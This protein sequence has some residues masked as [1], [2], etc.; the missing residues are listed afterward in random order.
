MTD[1]SAHPVHAI[2]PVGDPYVLGRWHRDRVSARG[3]LLEARVALKALVVRGRPERF[4]ILARPRSG[5]TLLYRLLA[6]FGPL[7]PLQ[8]EKALGVSKN[9]VRD[10]VA[11]LLAAGGA[12][13]N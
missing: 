1:L 3:Y 9:G 5:T 8:I 6:G 12:P 13:S 7:R 11:A 4:L 10:L 2:P